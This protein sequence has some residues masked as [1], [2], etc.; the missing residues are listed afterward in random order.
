MSTPSHPGGFERFSQREDVTTTLSTIAESASG[1]NEALADSSPD[2]DSSVIFSYVEGSPVV[3]PLASLEAPHS[4]WYRHSFRK[5]YIENTA[6]VL[7]GTS[8]ALTV[9]DKSF[10]GFTSSH[11]NQDMPQA[12][13]SKRLIHDGRLVGVMQRSYTPS[14]KSDAIEFLPGDG[15][16]DALDHEY[17]EDLVRTAAQ[18]A[19]LQSMA[20]GRGSLGL[21]LEQEEAIAPD[22][23]VIRFDTVDS[24]NYATGA[25]QAAYDAYQ[26]QCQI[27]VDDLIKDYE[28]RY[29]TDQYGIKAGYSDQGDGAYVIIP[30]PEA[31]NPYDTHVLED[32]KKYS[33]T[34][35]VEDMR[36]GLD[37]IA[38]QYK[39][40]LI[41][42]PRVTIGSAFGNVSINGRGRFVSPAM[43]IL[44][45]AKQ[46]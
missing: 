12:L 36:A 38:A 2:Y 1:L 22:S 17:R 23:T 10:N 37:A 4:L 45:Q 41:P 6:L 40:D 14:G 5:R 32:Y 29:L 26:N 28:K 13:H 7:S 39:N 24:R 33:I 43:T 34:P 30:L 46:K 35:F 19:L 18:I 25:Q 31:Y 44:A 9:R 27:F 21:L 11:I 3:N 42:T 8:L 20:E 15:E 16:I